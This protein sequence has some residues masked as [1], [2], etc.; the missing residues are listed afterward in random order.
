MPSEVASS[1]SGCGSC[2]QKP[3]AGDGGDDPRHVDHALPQQG[4]AVPCALDVV[5]AHRARRPGWRRR[6][7]GR[8]ESLRRQRRAPAA[9]RW[10]A[11]WAGAPGN[12]SA[13]SLR[14]V[15]PRRVTQQRPFDA[16]GAG[17]RRAF[18]ADGA[19]AVAD[20]VDDIGRGGTG[21]IG[22]AGEGR[23]GGDQ[24][25]A[26]AAT[27]EGEGAGGIGGGQLRADLAQRP[28]APGKS[29]RRGWCR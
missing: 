17:R 23:C 11:G 10:C 21:G 27:G 12:R 18:E 28:P 24:G 7:S 16:R 22:A 26:A 3:V 20:E 6:A 29:H 2:I 9:R 25:D 4:R 14:S 1:A 5:D 19:G 15:Q 13:L 8:P